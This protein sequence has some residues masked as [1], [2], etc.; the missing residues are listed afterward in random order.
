MHEI[1]NIEKRIDGAMDII[2]TIKPNLNNS[3]LL[4]ELKGDLVRAK[5]KLKRLEV[6][7]V[8]SDV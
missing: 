3:I 7:G 6:L 2:K 4:V 8:T 1:P 5:A